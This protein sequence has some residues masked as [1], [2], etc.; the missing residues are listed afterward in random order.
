MGSD[1]TGTQESAVIECRLP[2]GSAMRFKVT[3]PTA[4]NPETGLLE[5]PVI[6][7]DGEPDT[8]VTKEN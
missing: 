8:L 7:P 2:D 1:S 5:T 6:R 4:R 3:G